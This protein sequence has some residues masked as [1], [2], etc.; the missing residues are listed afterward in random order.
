MSLLTDNIFAHCFDYSYSAFL[1]RDYWYCYS[2]AVVPMYSVDEIAIVDYV[3]LDY[4]N[5]FRYRTIVDRIYNHNIIKSR[6]R[7][8]IRQPIN[9]YVFECFCIQ[10]HER[11]RASLN[12]AR[13]TSHFQQ[14]PLPF[15]VDPLSLEGF[16]ALS[17]SAIVDDSIDSFI[18]SS[19]TRVGCCFIPF[20]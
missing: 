3:L 13:Q 2:P 6:L 12:I 11:S 10:C 8:R 7:N 9:T 5:Q 16:V 15:D 17:M 18:F 20:R 19:S 4:S 14:N 1:I